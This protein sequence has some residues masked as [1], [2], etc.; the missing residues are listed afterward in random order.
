MKRQQKRG[1]ALC[2][3]EGMDL[4]VIPLASLGFPGTILFE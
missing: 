4:T 2:S 3:Q 1:K